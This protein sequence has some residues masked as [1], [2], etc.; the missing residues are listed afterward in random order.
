MRGPLIDRLFARVVE[1]ANGCWIFTGAIS[2]A[3][4][5]TIGRGPA[6]SGST[7]VH[8]ETYRFFIGE[9]P[10]GLEIDHLCRVT[11]CCN[12]WHLEAVTHAENSRRKPPRTHCLRGHELTPD[13]TDQWPSQRLCSTC[14]RER[15]R[16]YRERVAA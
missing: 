5:G 16:T 4:Y 11:A 13:N 1:D 10:N 8:R 7:Y 6:G 15:Q 12:P 14:R 3:G 9:I 2:K